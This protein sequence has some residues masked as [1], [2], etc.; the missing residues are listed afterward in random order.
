MG[1][2]PRQPEGIRGH[3]DLIA[4]GN[5]YALHRQ[6]PVPSTANVTQDWGEP[7]LD[8]VIEALENAYRDRAGAAHRG[9]CGAA[10][11][12]QFTWERQT[13]VLMEAIADLL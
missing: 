7:A 2:G 3:L 13:A 12:K 8:E 9:E 1:P 5:C 11:M 6:S 10:F 4:D